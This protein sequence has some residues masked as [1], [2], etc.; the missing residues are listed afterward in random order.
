[1]AGQGAKNLHAF[2]HLSRVASSQKLAAQ[3]SF[4][5][6]VLEVRREKKERVRDEGC[7]GELGPWCQWNPWGQGALSWLSRHCMCL[8]V[9]ARVEQD[10]PHGSCKCCRCMCFP[11]QLV[12]VLFRLPASLLQLAQHCGLRGGNFSMAVW[13][14]NQ[15]QMSA[16]GC[17]YT[18]LQKQTEDGNM[19]TS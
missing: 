11:P 10:K 5:P 16:C 2:H 15:E 3:V 14:H 17:D 9:R 4:V 19:P 8:A 18:A 12:P 6:C 7:T 1:M 13:S